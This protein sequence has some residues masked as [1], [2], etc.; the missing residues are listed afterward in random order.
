MA[1]DID[2]VD[3]NL[4]KAA[5]DEAILHGEMDNINRKAVLL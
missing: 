1:M 2:M 4:A 5:L 3:Q